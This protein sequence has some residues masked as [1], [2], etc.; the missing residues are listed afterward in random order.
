MG[1][2]WLSLCFLC[3]V[4]S[5][6]L[7]YLTIHETYIRT[8]HRLTKYVKGQIFRN[9]RQVFEIRKNVMV[10][11]SMLIMTSKAKQIDEL[12]PLRVW[13][14][15]TKISLSTTPPPPPS[16]TT[17]YNQ[18]KLPTVITIKIVIITTYIVHLKFK[19]E[20]ALL[21]K[22][23]RNMVFITFKSDMHTFESGDWSN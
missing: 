9:N 12:W 1:F 18:Q 4:L 10:K 13:L 8:P 15:E 14:G 3:S 21:Y 17:K 23:Y 22:S 5:F 16:T 6:C 7:F 11:Q 19:F 2:E 20:K